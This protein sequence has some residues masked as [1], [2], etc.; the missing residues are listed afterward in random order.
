MKP[1]LVIAA[2]SFG[3]LARVLAQECGRKVAG[4]I[5]DTKSAGDILGATSDLGR[6]L[7]PIEYELV[8]AIGYRHL[9]TRIALFR[10]LC[11]TGFYF[12]PLIHPAARVSQHARI[13]DGTIVMANADVDAFTVV[14]EACVIWPHATVSHD[15][16]IGCN[17][18]ISPAATLCGFVTIGQGSFIGANSTIIDGSTLKDGAFVKA[19]ARHHIKTK[20]P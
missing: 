16:N 13:G 5:D 7:T 19:S 4:F 10:R 15:N 12:P 1:L 20:A 11:A 6:S 9:D 2:S 3:H 8:M 17:T 14:G 18:F